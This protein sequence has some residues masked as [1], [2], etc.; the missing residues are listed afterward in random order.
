MAH[1]TE[2]DREFFDFG[3]IGKA[4]RSARKE[5]GWSTEYVAEMLD[6][7]SSHIKAIETKGINP[8]FQLFYN[9]ITMFNISVDEYFYAN[10]GLHISSEH[11]QLIELLTSCDENELYIVHAL[12]KGIIEIREKNI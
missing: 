2:T 9:L 3:P 6:V 7:T 5:K 1:Q 10:Q 12:L 4:I 8:G 11:R